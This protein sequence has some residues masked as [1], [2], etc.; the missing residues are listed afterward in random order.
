MLILNEAYTVYLGVC[1]AG[2]I[3]PLYFLLYY[4]YFARDIVRTPSVFVNVH[5]CY[6]IIDL[7]KFIRLY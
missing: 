5:I 4:Y 2:D 1:V 7:L 6:I 3:M